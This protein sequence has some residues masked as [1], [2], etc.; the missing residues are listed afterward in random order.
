MG[1]SISKSIVHLHGGNIGMTSEGKGKG[2]TFYIELP[3]YEEV[4]HN[5]K[6][7]ILS[8]IYDTV[9]EPSR[10]F[11][12][13]IS[14]GGG[15]SSR[16]LMRS[17]SSSGK[18][19][20]DHQSHHKNK[21]NHSRN[22]KE[23]LQV[24]DL[25]RTGSILSR[26]GRSESHVAKS[27]SHESFSSRHG[28][29]KTAIIPENG[30]NSGEYDIGTSGDI[31]SHNPTKDDERNQSDI[32]QG[33]HHH[34]H[35]VHDHGVSSGGFFRGLIG[36]ITGL[37]SIS[38]FKWQAPV[39]PSNELTSIEETEANG[40]NKDLVAASN[41][42]SERNHYKMIAPEPTSQDEFENG[43]P[44]LPSFSAGEMRIG[45]RESLQSG[46]LPDLTNNQSSSLGAAI[47][48]AKHL[49]YRMSFSSTPTQTYRILIVDDSAPNRKMLNRLLTRELHTVTEASDG[50]EAVE[51]VYE[52]M[53]AKSGRPNFDLILMDYY[54]SHMN[55]PEAIQAIRKLGY[56][57]M[58]LGVSGVIDDDSNNF[59]EAGANLVL[60]KPLTLSALWK[61]LRSTNFFDDKM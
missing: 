19:N 3:C 41:D 50:I 11:R 48:T 13:G 52:T 8:G 38:P 21:R 17:L 46:Q 59:I 9:I 20:S 26:N 37:A 15:H 12:S 7:A 54:M 28:D 40:D 34:H 2:S 5:N 4:S 39:I 35:H 49:R 61:S 31:A 55:G 32:E 60:C 25:E 56:T 18:S 53:Q 57:G 43:V 36:G 10:M 30:L 58:I 33:H 29:L 45:V 22:V 27:R 42:E 16:R 23:N 14:G 1:L 24:H 44:S 51:M 6:E 47:K